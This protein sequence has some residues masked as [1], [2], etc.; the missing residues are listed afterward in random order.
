ML[1]IR[2]FAERVGSINLVKASDKFLQKH[3]KA[4]SESEEFLAVGL[5][6]VS[7]LVGRDELHVISEE[8]VFLAVLRWIKQDQETRSL[9]LPALLQKVRLP[10]LT[11]QFLADRVATEELIRSSHQCRDLLDEARNYHLMPERRP[12]LKSFV[13]RA[14]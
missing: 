12:Q 2:T 13:T 11:P 7:E 8:V 10:L 9:H 4:V 5:E 6:D 14:R 1:G 3:F